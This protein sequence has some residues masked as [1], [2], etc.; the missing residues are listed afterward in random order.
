[1]LHEILH[2]DVKLVGVGERKARLHE[3][4]LHFCKWQ[5]KGDGKCNDG[6]LGRLVGLV[7][8]DLREEFS[9]NICLLVAL[10]VRHAAF[11]N[12]PQKHLR[13]TLI[14]LSQSIVK[15]CCLFG[16]DRHRK[17]DLFNS[18]IANG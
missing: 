10:C 7:R 4:I 8:A 13:K 14:D 15:G 9:V 1:M 3:H 17:C 6:E 5:L 2:D 11:I 18:F 12:L 16:A